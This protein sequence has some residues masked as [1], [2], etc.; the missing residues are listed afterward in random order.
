MITLRNR[1][2]LRLMLLVT[3]RRTWAVVKMM[4]L[5]VALLA[6]VIG[7]SSVN[8]WTMAV[9]EA[10]WPL[11]TFALHAWPAEL[12]HQ[13]IGRVGMGLLAVV[14]F[15][16][17]VVKN[18]QYPAPK[19]SYALIE[20]WNLGLPKPG[21]SR[22]SSWL[23]RLVMWTMTAFYLANM[24]ALLFSAGLLMMGTLTLLLLANVGSLLG[25]V[26]DASRRFR[27]RL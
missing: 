6:Y 25:H 14:V 5:M 26:L 10:A 11:R 27:A 19:G 22:T 20:R 8:L 7:F 23:D 21:V 15:W 9:V 1:T 2:A 12:L 4:A 17:F 16:S 13:T 24:S 18:R 3:V